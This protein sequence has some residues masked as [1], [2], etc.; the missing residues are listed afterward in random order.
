MELELVGMEVSQGRLGGESVD[1]AVEA[2]VTGMGVVE[3]GQRHQA[4]CRGMLG[5]HL[6]HN[7]NNSTRWYQHSNS[8]LNSTHRNNSHC[9]SNRSSGGQGMEVWERITM[10]EDGTHRSL[11]EVA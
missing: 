11:P 8:S 6:H 10:L 2:V 1:M 3:I 4:T 9:N 5:H 7:S